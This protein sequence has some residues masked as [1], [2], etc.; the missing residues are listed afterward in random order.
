MHHTQAARRR[1]SPALRQLM[2]GY[3]NTPAFVMNRTLDLLAVN[4]LAQA[5][6]SGAF[7]PADNLARMTF[8]DPAGPTFYT[9][10]NRTSDWSSSPG[11]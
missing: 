8:L 9:D 11:N 5:L 7:T 3:P 2:D 10:W 1:V 6:Y 4:A